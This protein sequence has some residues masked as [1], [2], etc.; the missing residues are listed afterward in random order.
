[1]KKVVLMCRVHC[2]ESTGHGADIHNVLTVAALDVLACGHETT[3]SQSFVW[4]IKESWAYITREHLET[5][6]EDEGMGM[7]K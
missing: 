1:M 3:A 6:V 5:Q 2:L 7:R 4:K